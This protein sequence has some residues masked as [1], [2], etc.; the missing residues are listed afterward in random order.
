MSL[1]TYKRDEMRRKDELLVVIADAHD[2]IEDAEQELEALASSVPAV[3]DWVIARGSLI[4]KVVALDPN[5][6]QA[7]YTLRGVGGV[8]FSTEGAMTVIRKSGNKCLKDTDVFMEP[9][10]GYVEM[11]ETVHEFMDGFYPNEFILQLIE[12]FDGGNP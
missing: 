12:A 5:T 3:G 4:C 11:A 10:S 9:C 2:V 6:C 1:H 7:R 8:I